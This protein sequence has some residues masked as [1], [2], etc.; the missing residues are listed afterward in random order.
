MSHRAILI[1]TSCRGGRPFRGSPHRDVIS[2]TRTP[3]QE[4]ASRSR[5]HSDFAVEEAA[6]GGECPEAVLVL[7][8]TRLLDRDGH[9]RLIFPRTPLL[10]A[11]LWEAKHAS[12]P[13][14]AAAAVAA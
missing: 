7:T 4:P 9:P 8:V 5:C 1:C 3:P 14:A 11:R 2:Q 12:R 10:A 13:V 6:I